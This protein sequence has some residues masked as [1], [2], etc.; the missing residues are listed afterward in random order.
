MTST[1]RDDKLH[2]MLAVRAAPTVAK[3]LESFT[4]PF[5][6]DRPMIGDAVVCPE[7]RDAMNGSERATH[8]GSCG[9]CWKTGGNATGRPIAFVEH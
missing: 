3:V 9:L 4:L 5:P 6:T 1:I 8:C 2:R 7:Q